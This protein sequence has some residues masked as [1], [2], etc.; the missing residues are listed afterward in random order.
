M[1]QLSVL[2]FFKVL[3][4]F[5]SLVFSSFAVEVY[6]IYCAIHYSIL[7]NESFVAILHQKSM[8]TMIIFVI[9]IFSV[10]VTERVQL[11]E[12]SDDG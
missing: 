1:N 6:L 3:L 5:L 12:G 7:Q 8:G 11:A 10:T 2:L 4:F 9:M